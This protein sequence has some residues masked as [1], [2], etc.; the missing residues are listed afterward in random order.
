MNLNSNIKTII[1]KDKLVQKAEKQKHEQNKR[2]SEK[3]GLPVFDMENAIKLLE[4][5][6]HEEEEDEDEEGDMLMKDIDFST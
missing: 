6:Y 1:P 4:G 5:K 3:R 2:A